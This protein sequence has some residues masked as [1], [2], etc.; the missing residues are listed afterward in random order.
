MHRSLALAV[1]VALTSCRKPGTAENQPRAGMASATPVASSPVETAR[2]LALSATSQTTAVDRRI[3]ALAKLA[4]AH[5][6]RGDVLVDLGRAW[7]QKA[8]ESSD[9]G[10]Y[11]Q[12]GACADV[13][14]T[15]APDDAKALDLRAL[16]LLNDHKFREARDV[17]RSILQK[18]ESA[19]TAWGSLSDALLEL[20]DL[21][22]ADR[23]AQ[24]MM[25]LKPNLSS[26]IRVSYFQWLAGNTPG[27]IESARLAIDAGGDAKNREPRAWAIVQAAMLFWHRGD[28]EG[29]DAGFRQALEVIGDYPLALVGR[30]RVA[31]AQ[32]RAGEAARHFERAFAKSPLVETAWLL[33]EA[34]E[35]VSDV[36]GASAAFA[37]AEKEG[38]SSDR[39]T[40]SLMYSSRK[41]NLESALAL[42]EEESA[43]RGGV[44]TDDALAW[45]LYRNGRFPEAKT[46]IERARRYGTSDARLLFHHGAIEKALGHVAAGKKLVSE[47]LRLNPEFE[48]GG[49]AEARA[50][51]EER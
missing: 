3:A 17:A 38:R 21:E 48:P 16:V 28:Y 20:G 34:R 32:G 27:A 1:V 12:A 29:A 14:L 31:M 45:A 5:P 42:A 51:V 49:A 15:I 41:T 44:Y 33:G 25:D 35:R 9:P 4:G 10:Y 13:A 37:A 40:L 50:L 46:A 47:A 43:T 18:E 2:R 26:Y 8:R 7:I 19:V 6:D 23:A 22:E 30:G 36:P 11:L 39:R 24:R